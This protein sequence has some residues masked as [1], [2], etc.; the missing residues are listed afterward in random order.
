[1][2]PDSNSGAQST[3]SQ[4]TLAL[5]INI[6][7]QA[8]QVIPGNFVMSPD[9]LFQSLALLLTGADGATRQLL[10][11]CLGDDYSEPAGAAASSA[12][13]C[14][15]DEYCV[16]NCLLLSNSHGLQETYR[17]KLKQIN[18]DIRDNVDFSDRASLQSLAQELNNLFCQLTHGMVPRFCQESD[19]Q[20]DTS[21]A[22]INSVYFKGLW[23]RSFKARS[24][25]TVFTLPN[26]QIV[27]LERFMDGVI[28]SSG[29]ANY[30]DW[31]AVTV[32]Y[33]G[34]HEMILVL[35]PERIM[36]H[37]VS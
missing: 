9:G 23:E 34:A 12:T 30:N 27:A 1:M 37:E 10:Q 2:N 22:L 13:A 26:G 25:E 16:A 36:P 24:R 33:R 19:W 6:F 14:G 29:Y 31:E 7:R 35:P 15:Q 28:N 5:A 18:A 17:E 21:L 20:A 11:S 3:E 8:A 32:P 4:G